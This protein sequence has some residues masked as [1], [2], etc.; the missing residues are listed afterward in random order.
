MKCDI[1]QIEMREKEIAKDNK[2]A[3]TFICPYCHAYTVLFSSGRCEW[4][5]ADGTLFSPKTINFSDS[6]HINVE[7]NK[8]KEYE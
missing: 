8:V 1:C 2:K 7:R 4:H 5:R 6:L 3:K